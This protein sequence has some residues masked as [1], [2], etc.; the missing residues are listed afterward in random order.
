M[1]NKYTWKDVKAFVKCCDLT[2]QDVRKM[3][4]EIN[5]DEEIDDNADEVW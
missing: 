3:L 2:V 1:N 4:S 5:T